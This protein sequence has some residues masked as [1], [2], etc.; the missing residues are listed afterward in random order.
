[1]QANERQVYDDGRSRDKGV[2]PEGVALMEIAGR[3]YA[4]VG[5]ERT[6]SAAVA[7]FDITNPHEAKFLDMIVTAGD[8]HPRDWRF[9]LRGNHYLAIANVVS[10]GEDG[11]TNTTL[12]RI[13]PPKH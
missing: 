5:L 9:K 11:P 6:L 7:I 3:T 12:Y 13:D 8:V 2:E 4:F 10:V 1:M